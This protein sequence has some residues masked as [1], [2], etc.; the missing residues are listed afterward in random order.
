MKKDSIYSKSL[1]FPVAIAATL[2]VAE[3]FI[4]AT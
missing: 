4:Q 1:Q 3:S 2:V